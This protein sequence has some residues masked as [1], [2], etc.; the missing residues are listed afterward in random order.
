MAKSCVLRYLSAHD[1]INS[2]ML[3]AGERNILFDGIGTIYLSWAR[4]SVYLG[5]F[6]NDARNNNM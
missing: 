6:L 4:Q 2:P 3:I 5:M 1:G